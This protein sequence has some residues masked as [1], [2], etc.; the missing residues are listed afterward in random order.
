MEGINEFYFILKNILFMYLR[1][2]EREHASG[3]GAEGKGQVDSVLSSEQ[4]YDP[5]IMN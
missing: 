1:E 4:S 3:G 5:E 2:R